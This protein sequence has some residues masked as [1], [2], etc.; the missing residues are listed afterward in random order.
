VSKS[1]P[2]EFTWRLRIYTD[3]EELMLN[4]PGDEHR[5]DVLPAMIS[6]NQRDPESAHECM[7]SDEIAEEMGGD[8]TGK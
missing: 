3:A 2:T 5:F 7:V 1:Y 4:F 8:V 6:G